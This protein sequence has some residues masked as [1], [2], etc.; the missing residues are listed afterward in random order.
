MSQF[1][2]KCYI[3]L[4]M[5]RIVHHNKIC[6]K[7]VEK[8]ESAFEGER[9]ESMILMK[10]YEKDGCLYCKK[11][12]KECKL[13]SNPQTDDFG[14]YSYVNQSCGYCEDDYSGLIY[15]KTPVKNLWLRRFY[16]CY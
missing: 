5:F 15:T 2:E 14:F 10:C 13:S 4:M 6:E 11:D 12:G 7:L 3:M 1:L 9:L 16:S 8:Y